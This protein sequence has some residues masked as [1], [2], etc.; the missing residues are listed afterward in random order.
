MGERIQQY[1][2]RTAGRLDAFLGSVLFGARAKRIQQ[3]LKFRSVAVNGAVISRGAHEVAVGD[4]VTIHFD[5]GAPRVAPL[6]AGLKVVYEDEHLL[7]VDKPPG[8]LTIATEHERE[9]TAYAIL[10]DYVR[11]RHPD[12][13]VF[14]VHRLDKGTSGLVLFAR[15]EP[16]KRALQERWREVE[17]HYLAV[18]QGTPPQKQGTLRSHLREN[19]GLEVYATDGDEGVEAVTHYEVAASNRRYALL[20]VRLETG[21]KNQIRVQ[22]ADLGF[23]VVGD[24]KYGAQD[25]PVGRLALHASRISLVHPVRG[26]RIE[27]TS[28]LPPRL[29]ALV[30]QGPG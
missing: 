26:E 27:L 13:R 17:K 24:R 6:A 10:T 12:A 9:R 2:V 22:L 19:R 11:E 5:G 23:P 1:T 25:S 30:G 16:V 14:I 8:L 21:R 3:L 29:Q 20:D 28:P 15:S 18:V 4:L 7:A